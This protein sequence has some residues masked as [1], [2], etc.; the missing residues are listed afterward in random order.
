MN[1]DM[2][3]SLQRSWALRRKRRAVD[4]KGLAVALAFLIVMFFV[5]RTCS[6][7]NEQVGNALQELSTEIEKVSAGKSAREA[8]S[9]RT[10]SH[11]LNDSPTP[12]V[13]S[14]PVLLG[15]LPVPAVAKTKQAYIYVYGDNRPPRHVIE[16]KSGSAMWGA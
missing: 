8:E 3:R 11:R 15:A 14:G 5:V 13:C 1:Q 7:R 16:R 10:L 6:D 4:K 12:F 2:Y 9:S